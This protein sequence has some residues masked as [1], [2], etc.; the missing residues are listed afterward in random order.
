MDTATSE[1]EKATTALAAV[2]MTAPARIQDHTLHL[3]REQVDILKRTVCKN[4]TDDE[5]AFFLAVARRSGLDPFARQIHAVKR[6]DRDTDREVMTIQT[7]IDGYRLIAQ[8]TKEMDGQDGPYWCGPDGIWK[9][10]WL[11]DEPP[12][13][14]KVTVFRKGHAHPYTG[15][16]RYKAY[17]QRKKNGEPNHFWVTMPDGQLAKCCEALAL[18]KGF[19]AELSGIYADEEMEQADNIRTVKATVKTTS[20]ATA[21]TEQ[22][23]PTKE[24]ALRLIREKLLLVAKQVLKTKDAAVARK[25]L[26]TFTGVEHEADLQENEIRDLGKALEMVKKGAAKDEAGDIIECDQEGKP[27]GKILWKKKDKFGGEVRKEKTTAE[28]PPAKEETAA[29]AT[30]EGKADTGDEQP[31]F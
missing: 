16:A 26:K 15:I 18:R 3:S 24:E 20:S 12:Y 9:D 25:Y 4:S 7:G 30:A 8:R 29:A 17:V 21:T 27:V 22:A 5:L 13:A 23:A 19:P 11:S 6:Y 31:L 10:V 2:Q 1:M 28:K 14:A